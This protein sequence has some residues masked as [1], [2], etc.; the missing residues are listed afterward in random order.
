[1]QTQ[2]ANTRVDTHQRKGPT[3]HKAKLTTAQVDDMREI[4]ES[5]GVTY[6][7]LAEV[8]K[9]GLCT[10]RDIVLYRTRLHG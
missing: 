10:A 6:A 8:F 9:C 2:K 1:M 4:Y 5:G 7:L 3:H